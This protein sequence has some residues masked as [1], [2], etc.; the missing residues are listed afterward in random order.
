L[1]RNELSRNPRKKWIVD[2]GVCEINLVA[3]LFSAL[4]EMDRAA[5]HLG[6]E[7]TSKTDAKPAKS[8]PE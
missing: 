7:L 4:P 3:A 6:Q 2:P 1:K 5:K 8:T